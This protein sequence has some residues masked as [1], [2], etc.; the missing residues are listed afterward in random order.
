MRVFIYRHF[1]SH[2]VDYNSDAEQA[3]DNVDNPVINVGFHK[4]IGIIFSVFVSLWPAL[5][6]IERFNPENLAQG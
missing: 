6:V 1:H 5:V 4:P 3:E 2:R